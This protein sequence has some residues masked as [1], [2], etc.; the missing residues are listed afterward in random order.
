MAKDAVSGT[1]FE[2]WLSINKKKRAVKEQNSMKK[3]LYGD[4]IYVDLD[5]LSD[6][7]NIIK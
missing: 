4:G 3:V 6:D 1:D 2:E 7:E 5:T